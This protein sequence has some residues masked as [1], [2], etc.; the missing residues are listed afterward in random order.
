M[1]TMT[2]G[3]TL[4]FPFVQLMKNATGGVCGKSVSSIQSIT[5]GASS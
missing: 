3:F 4:P 2:H 5:N 1:M